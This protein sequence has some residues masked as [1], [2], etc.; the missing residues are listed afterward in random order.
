M[1]HVVRGSCVREID[2]P[3]NHA[4]SQLLTDAGT[5]SPLKAPFFTPLIGKP[6]LHFV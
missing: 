4:A 5:S 3:L 6:S 2:V 1:S